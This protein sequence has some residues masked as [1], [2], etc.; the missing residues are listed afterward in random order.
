M[1]SHAFFIERGRWV[2]VRKEERVCQACGVIEDELIEC[3]RF[4]N[5][6]RGLLPTILKEESNMYEF[7]KFFNSESRPTYD[8][9]KLG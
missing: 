6:R 7:V 8:A 5:E 4:N 3:P 9:R 1:S 2:K